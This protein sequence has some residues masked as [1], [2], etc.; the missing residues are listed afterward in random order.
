MKI[1]D[2]KG[3]ATTRDGGCFICGKP[4]HMAKDCHKRVVN[5]VD[6]NKTPPSSSGAKT[7]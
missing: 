5:A 4:G 1:G 6:D 2:G 7:P 3:K